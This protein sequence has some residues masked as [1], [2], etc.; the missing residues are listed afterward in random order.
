LTNAE[1]KRRGY[2]DEFSHKKIEQVF[3]CSLLN[4]AAST[5]KL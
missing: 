4:Y 5:R 2:Q 1:K 3:A